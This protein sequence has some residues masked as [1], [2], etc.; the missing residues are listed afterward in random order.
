MHEYVM[1]GTLVWKFGNRELHRKHEQLLGSTER[2]I[3][4]LNEVI[5]TGSSVIRT[6]VMTGGW[7]IKFSPCEDGKLQIEANDWA[8]D[9]YAKVELMEFSKVLGAFHRKVLK[10]TFERHPELCLNNSFITTTPF[11][12]KL[13]REAMNN[14]IEFMRDRVFNQT[15]TDINP[16]DAELQLK[17]S[18][19]IIRLS[20]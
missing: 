17:D 15:V 1:Q 2:A 3:D 13:A 14:S 19:Q 10:E 18:A 12:F 5:Y 4:C 20:K 16:I 11:G 7:N 9:T 6:S 8:R